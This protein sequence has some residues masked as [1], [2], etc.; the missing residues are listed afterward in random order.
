MKI[1]ILTHPL[2]NNYGGILQN[3]ALQQVLMRL[4]HEVETVDIDMRPK[5]SPIRMFIGWLN[6]LRLHYLSGQN[7]AISLNPLPSG[8]Q[9]NI[10][11]QYTL[12][13]KKQHII[14]TE[15]INNLK[16][17]YDIDQKHKFDAYVV[18]SDQVWIKDFCPWFFGSFIERDDTEL[19]SYAASFGHSDWRFD[20]QLTQECS[21]LA[22]RFKAISVREDSGIDLCRNYLGVEAIH[23][24]DPTMLLEPKDYLKHIDLRKEKNILFAYILDNNPLKE[25]IV[26]DISSAKGLIPQ[27]GMPEQN[28]VRGINPIEKCIFPPVDNWLNGFNNADF[29][30]TDSF[31]GTVFAILFNVPFIAIGNKRRGMARFESLLRMFHLEDR[32]VGTLEEAISIS[33]KPIDFHGVNKILATQRENALKFLSALK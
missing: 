16:D 19:I 6:R 24:I 22:K 18:G 28:F 17:L 13:F 15:T 33:K 1:G 3:F 8:K 30:I 23:V 2:I 26:R 7:V 25:S 31:H 12:A 11:N 5:M 29:V 20:N 9:Y 21:N 27:S 14:C 4:G 32:L 10:L